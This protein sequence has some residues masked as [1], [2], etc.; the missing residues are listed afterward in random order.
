VRPELL[1]GLRGG[2]GNFGVVTEFEFRLY[3]VGPDV[4]FAFVLYPIAEAAAV[5]RRHEE[6]VEADAGEISTLAV[7][8]F[9]P[10]VPDI[11]EA[12]HG[13]PMVGVLGM[14]AG[15]PSAGELALRPFRE[16]TDPLVD[17]SAVM[18][19]VAAQT[20]YDADYPAG[21]RYY[22]KS[23]R[24]AALGDEVVEILVRHTLAAPSLHSTIDLWLNGGAMAAVA[25]DAT[26]FGRRDIR[27]LVSPEAN[28]EDPADDAANIEWLRA[29]LRDLEPHAAGG[30]YLNFPGLL[31]EGDALVRASLDATYDRLARLKAEYDPDNV[32]SRNH[33]IPPRASGRS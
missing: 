26:A 22:W 33:N 27:Y 28:W 30:A 12:V 6:L 9:V 21:H 23:S 1:W 8:G 13:V 32:F 11:D 25:A 20:I 16:I 19:Y 17:L 15:D 10:A 5:L 24:M 3:P 14:H 31:E 4:A 29:L 7:L 18:P 2:G